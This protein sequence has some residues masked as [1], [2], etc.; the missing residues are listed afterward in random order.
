MMQ[1]VLFAARREGDKLEE[2]LALDDMIP[3]VSN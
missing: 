2:A 3:I 1:Q